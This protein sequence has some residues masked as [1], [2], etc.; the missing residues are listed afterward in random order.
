MQRD[1]AAAAS[2]AADTLESAAAEQAAAASVAAH[3]ATQLEA[4]LAAVRIERAT[5]AKAR[6]TSTQ[7]AQEA[8]AFYDKLTMVVNAATAAG[9][10]GR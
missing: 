3:E 4:Q 1:A 8:A 5:L 9:S 10:G 7:Q 2:V 6:V